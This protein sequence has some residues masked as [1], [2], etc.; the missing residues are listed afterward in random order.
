[1]DLQ[2]QQH[3]VKVSDLEEAETEYEQ[4]LKQ[5][6]CTRL[7]VTPWEALNEE[8]R[9]WIQ[10]D[11]ILHPTFYLGGQQALPDATM[12]GSGLQAMTSTKRGQ[13]SRD[14]DVYDM[15]RQTYERTGELP[16][17][18]EAQWSSYTR[19]ALSTL[20]F[21]PLDDIQDLQDRHVKQLL[22]KYYVPEGES[23]LGQKRFK[24]MRQMDNRLTTIIEKSG[25]YNEDDDVDNAAA[26]DAPPVRL[27]RVWGGWDAIHPAAAGFHSQQQLFSMSC[28][29]CMVNHPAAYAIP[30]RK[31]EFDVEEA[32]QYL[33]SPDQAG[34][35]GDD[36]QA[37]L[38]SP[39]KH[40]DGQ[41]WRYIVAA[42]IESLARV[43]PRT[44]NGR[45]CL[46]IQSERE[47]LLTEDG[48]H[49]EPRQSKSHRFTIN[50]SEP[51]KP[52]DILVT[53]TFQ[54]V[55]GKKGYRLGRLAATLLQ[56]PRDSDDNPLP[57]P[58]GYAP[59]HLQS[60]N[61]PESLGKISILHTPRNRPLQSNEFQ[62]TVGAV[63]AVT[64][65]IVV[66]SKVAVVASQVL[67]EALERAKFCAARL[68]DCAAEL[69]EL[70]DSIRIAER[71]L[72]VVEKMIQEGKLAAEQCRQE[73]K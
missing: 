24:V 11:R 62:I 64:Y 53:V 60:L 70:S 73:I 44:V 61:T 45:A 38:P 68:P 65:T 7:R 59:Y 5:R 27:A 69:L 43:D 25:N 54:G 35:D 30:E 39:T 72:L 52:L 15:A 58:V 49:L 22:E 40:T 13:Y 1:M 20:Y 42:S 36:P 32:L 8:E 33:K 21:K 14:G 28:Y 47:T 18:A 63:T 17:P 23:R 4:M 2:S 55:F 29:N 48:V 31:Q 3:H 37:H 16:K 66:T 51:K 19:A 56:L 41:L 10:L 57:K 34:G 26:E 9:V 6:R 71:K 67:N 50:E 12:S 46:V